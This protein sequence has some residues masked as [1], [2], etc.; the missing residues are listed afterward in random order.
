MAAAAPVL[1][2]INKRLWELRKK[3]KRISHMDES[4][5]QGK[6]LNKEQEETLRSKPYVVAGIDELE[7][8]RQ[9]LL[10]AV[11]QEI[12]LTP[13][14]ANDNMLTR[15]H[16]RNCCLTSDYVIDDDAAGDPLKEWDLDVI[17]TVAGLL[18]SRPVNLSLSH[19]HSLE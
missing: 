7:K 1:N 10:S 12:E 2:L 13:M 19:K 8:I 6:T 18:I 9:P 14:R 15:T 3:L 11:D 17:A 4:H 5:A 16:E